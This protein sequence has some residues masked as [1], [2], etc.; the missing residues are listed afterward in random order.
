MPFYAKRYYY[1][2]PSVARRQK[3]AALGG[4]FN[5]LD[6]TQDIWADSVNGDD[7][8]TQETAYETLDAAVMAALLVG[9]GVHLVLQEIGQTPQ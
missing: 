2:D 1:Y 4:V 8:L 6:L 3:A 9:N 5:P 7:G